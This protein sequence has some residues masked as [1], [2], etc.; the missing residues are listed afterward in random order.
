M[1]YDIILK[2]CKEKNVKITNV[3]KELHMSSGN[4]NRWKNGIIPHGDNLKKLADYFGVSVDYLL[5]NNESSSPL[6]KDSISE[7]EQLILSKFRSLTSHQQ[8]K[9]IYYMDFI[10]EEAQMKSTIRSS[11]KESV[12]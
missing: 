8:E 7:T 1:F 5:G 9:V 12:S 6:V 11:S 10:T 4:M 2:L 3:V